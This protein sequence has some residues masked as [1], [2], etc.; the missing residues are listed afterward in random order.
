MP[1]VGVTPIQF[2][3]EH[4]PKEA[5]TTVTARYAGERFDPSAEEGAF[6]FT[7]LRSL[8]EEL[9]YEFHANEEKGNVLKAVIREDAAR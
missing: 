2:V 3:I 1:L 9:T 7:V 5:I 6:S 4:S 8:V